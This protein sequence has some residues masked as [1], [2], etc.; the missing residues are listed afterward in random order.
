MLKSQN[1]PPIP[2]YPR[3]LDL[4]AQARTARRELYPMT[5]FYGPLVLLVV[6]WTVSVPEKRAVGLAFFGAGLF[7]WTLVEYLVHRY[8]LHPPFP[9][10]KGIIRHGLH[11][12]F[13]NLHWEHHERPWDGKHLSGSVSQ[14][15]PFFL[16]LGAASL[17][18]PL[19]TGPLM[20]AGLVLGYVIEEWMHYSAHFERL[21]GSYFATM[22][23]YHLR[24]HNS[25]EG[26]DYGFGISSYLWDIVA[27][28]LLPPPQPAA[29]E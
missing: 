25:P 8:V 20:F 3:G 12:L 4:A 16:L 9:D 29:K 13:D 18:S 17:L 2:F 26:L 14:T 28:T 24:H 27:G 22:R 6:G 19:H 11:R 23:R 1:P 10:G 7:L 21:P 15:L 5:L